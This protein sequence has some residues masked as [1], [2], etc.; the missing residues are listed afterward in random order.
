MRFAVLPPAWP[1]DALAATPGPT[2]A[3]EPAQ[4]AGRAARLGLLVAVADEVVG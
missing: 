2:A 4:E 3:Q 1:R